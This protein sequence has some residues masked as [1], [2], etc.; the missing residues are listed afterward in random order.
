MMRG[1]PPLAL[2]L[3][4]ALSG[5]AAAYAQSPRDSSARPFV[6][7]GVDDKPFL[8]GFFGRI[9]LGGYVEVLSEMEREDGVT[10][11]WATEMTRVN[12][13]VS[14]TF[15]ERVN[16]F[17]EIEFEEAGE[18]IV[19]ELAQVDVFMMPALNARAGMLLLPLGRFNLTHDG[20][21]NELPSRPLEAEALLGVA[22]A[23]PGVGAYGRFDRASGMRFT[24]EGY[25]VNGYHE[26]LLTQSPEGTR[27]PAGKFNPEDANATPG[28]VGRFEWSPGATSAWGVSGYHGPYNVSTLDGLQVDESRDV[29]VG[30]LDLEQPIGPLTVS[31]EGALVR[32][33][34]PLTLTGLFAE[35][36]LGAYLQLAWAFG[37]SPASVPSDSWFTLAARFDGVDFDHDLDG[38]S[39][40]SVTLGANYRPI[41]E[42]ALK[43][44]FVRGETRDRFNNLAAFARIELGLASYF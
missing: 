4:L 2:F 44:A 9:R 22:L 19:V 33:Q 13:M 43:L 16:F 15:R 36:Q 26:G 30:V 27:L 7:G 39:I 11:G 3:I 37:R 14:T 1:T 31:G 6:A 29:T 8:H 20:P 32:V 18:E 5:P 24:Y 40:R 10:R 34:V 35:R 28:W 21:R 25:A 17:A 42:T 38:D 12:L 41:P 23:Q